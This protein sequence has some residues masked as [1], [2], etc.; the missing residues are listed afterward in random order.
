VYV[1][2]LSDLLQLQLQ[3]REEWELEQ[4]KQKETEEEERRKEAERLKKQVCIYFIF[5]CDLFNVMSGKVW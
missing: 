2:L 1:C 4:K 3:I 5:V